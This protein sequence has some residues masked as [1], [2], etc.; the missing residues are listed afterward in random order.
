M[1]TTIQLTSEYASNLNCLFFSPSKKIG[2]FY[3]LINYIFNSCVLLDDSSAINE[4]YSGSI[5]IVFVRLDDKTQLDSCESV[6]KIIKILRKSNESLLVYV[7]KSN[8]K[9]VD[10]LRKI[11]ES[12]CFD[13][14]LP[15]PF[16]RNRVYGFLYRILQR[17]TTLKDLQAYVQTLEDQLY[18]PAVTQDTKH[19]QKQLNKQK[20]D[21]QQ[22][23]IRFTQTDKISAIE[24]MESLDDAIIDKVE[25]L[26][27]ELNEIVNILYDMEE[28][29]ADKAFGYIPSVNLVIDKICILV[30]SIGVFDVI[31][32]A[33]DSLNIFLQN[34]TMAELSDLD[35]KSMFVAM[36]LAIISD[37]EKWINTV[38]I[39]VQTD[40]I[41]YFDASFSSNIK[42]I[43]NLFS[44]TH[45]DDE[46]DLEFF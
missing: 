15:T 36:L 18:I 29:E 30:D 10:L 14:S 44:T 37:L 22:N 20:A 19:K 5:D 24:F 17:I 27:D 32:R 4:Q 9:D 13:G 11:N 7:I 21:R 28:A 23:D 25:I 2:P 6:K 41:H 12:Y 40:N 8:I 31:A 45:E 34:L 43:E 35:R 16:D 46:D 1:K 39:S 33:F 38:F 42:E 3:D 26:S